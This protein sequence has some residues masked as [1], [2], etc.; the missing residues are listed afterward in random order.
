MTFPRNWQNEKRDEDSSLTRRDFLRGRNA[1]KASKLFA[2]LVNGGKGKSSVIYGGGRGIFSIIL[3]LED[4][5][6]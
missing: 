4:S 5:V 6:S 3:P 1:A 2:L